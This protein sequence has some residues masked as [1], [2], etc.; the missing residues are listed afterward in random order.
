LR[1]AA[2][3]LGWKLRLTTLGGDGLAA[4]LGLDRR[5]DFSGVE[6]EDGEVLLE[7]TATRA[8]EDALPRFGE[9]I[10]H[11]KANMLDPHPMYHWPVIEEAAAATRQPVAPSGQIHRSYPPGM[12][13][14]S[15]PAAPIILGRRSAQR[16]DP[17]FTLPAD[18]FYRLLDSLLIRDCAPWDVWDFVPRLHPVIFVH[19]VSGLEAGVYFLSRRSSIA[20]RLKAASG[21]DLLW[22]AVPQAPAYLPLFRLARGDQRRTARALS[23]MQAIAGDSA[24]SLGMIAEF[25]SLVET[26]PWRYRQLHWEAGLIGQMLYLEAESMGLAGTGI[27]CFYDDDVHQALGLS[28]SAFQSLYHFTVGMAIA[29]PRISTEPAYPDRS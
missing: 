6:A 4:L 7:V 25:S 17:R 1:M 14:I 13:A 2:G 5:G 22:E 19:R 24:F 20:D 21:P 3:L 9:G 27:G 15:D 16:F 12:P 18:D 11:G 28:G 10:W 29:D 8:T 26:A 23:C